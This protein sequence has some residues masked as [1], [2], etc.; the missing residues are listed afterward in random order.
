MKNPD[1]PVSIPAPTAEDKP[2]QIGDELTVYEA[3]MVYAGR[4]PYPHMFGP[5]DDGNKSERCRTLLKVGLSKAP[6]ESQ[7]AQ[8][9]WDVFRELE[10]RIEKG[11]IQPPK[12]VYDF[13]GKLD[14]F[15]TVIQTSDLAR[16]AKARDERPTYL[17]HL[18][19]PDVLS[20]DE[21]KVVHFL[22][23]KLKANPDMKRKDAWEICR[24]QFPA[25]S[26]NGFRHRVWWSARAAAN[27]PAKAPRGRKKQK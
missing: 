24:G 18:R 13:T 19:L 1:P 7:H 21:Q 26:W 22:A 8:L 10:K 17:R 5:Y 27:L 6:S 11:E 14:P 20:D 16:L 2:F 23:R 9:S 4:H 15:W 25:L 12:P 3:A